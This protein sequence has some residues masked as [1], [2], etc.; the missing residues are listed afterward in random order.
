MERP[1]RGDEYSG[2]MRDPGWTTFTKPLELLEPLRRS[3]T[4]SFIAGTENVEVLTAKDWE[5]YARVAFQ[6]DL[7]G[8]TGGSAYAG[9]CQ[10]TGTDFLFTSDCGGMTDNYCTAAGD[11]GT[12]AFASTS[13]C[14]SRYVYLEKPYVDG[15]FE[16]G[17]DADAI[18]LAEILIYDVDGNQLTPVTVTAESTSTLEYLTDGDMSTTF[19]RFSRSN[20]HIQLDLGADY[21]VRTVLVYPRQKSWAYIFMPGIT[22]T[23]SLSAFLVCC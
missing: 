4:G 18:Q 21:N 8:L 9:N 3:F 6:N 13:E 1:V 5:V 15:W 11:A 2:L 22:V 16:F 20:K 12:F 19:V 10:D 14:L 17:T 7:T 23:R